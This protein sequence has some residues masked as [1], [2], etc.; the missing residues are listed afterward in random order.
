M[1]PFGLLGGG[2][3]K[4][5]CCCC[6]GSVEYRG[7]ILI[8]PTSGPR[9]STSRLIRLQ[10]SSISCKMKA[11]QLI[12]APLPYANTKK[13]TTQKTNKFRATPAE[14]M[15]ADRGDRGGMEKVAGGNCGFL[16]QYICS[17]YHSIWWRKLNLDCSML[18]WAPCGSVVKCSNH[19]KHGCAH[20]EGTNTQSKTHSNR[21]HYSTVQ[22]CRE[23]CDMRLQHWCITSGK[24][25]QISLVKLN[26]REPMGWQELGRVKCQE[27]GNTMA[28]A[29]FE[30]ILQNAYYN[31]IVLKKNLSIFYAS[32][33]LSMEN[34]L[35]FDHFYSLLF[36]SSYWKFVARTKPA[37][38]F[39]LYK[40]L[41]LLRAII[42]YF[43]TLI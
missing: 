39:L 15:A 27:W 36:L 23:G 18:C 42:L 8:S 35:Y 7:M 34:L 3:S 41:L 37:Q 1:A 9:S 24:S 31:I 28:N 22:Y 16:L 32:D 26:V 2:G 11:R 33:C 13:K 43:Q 12:P 10:A 38:Q 14:T 30:L 29:R 40:Q 6:G 21:V 19:G 25:W 5:L 20:S 17:N 4:I